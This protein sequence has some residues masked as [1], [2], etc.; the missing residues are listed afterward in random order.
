[1]EEE[2]LEAAGVEMETSPE[3]GEAANVQIDTDEGVGEVGDITEAVDSGLE[4]SSELE[5]VQAVVE[6]AAGEGE[7]LDPIAAEAIRIAVSAIASKIGANPKAVYS[8]YAVENFQSASSRRANTQIALEGVQEFLK[9]LW[10]KIKDAL[11]KLWAKAKAFWAKHVSNVGQVKKALDSM[12]AKVKASSGKFSGK[13]YLDKAP[14]SLVSAFPGKGDLNAKAVEGFIAGIEGLVKRAGVVADVLAGSA[15]KDLAAWKTK[16]DSAVGSEDSFVVVGGDKLTIKYDADQEEGA[17]KLE[18]EREPVEDKEEERGMTVG[19]KATLI[20]LLDQALASIKTTIELQK[21]ADK[22]AQAASTFMNDI[23]KEI[24]AAN[25]SPED[26]KATRTK[27]RLGYKLSAFDAKI[28]SIAA[29]ENVKLCRAV[30]GF[31]AV[32]LKQYK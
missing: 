9:D 15:G 10:K 31:A 32:S 1:M 16:I 4:A 23:E 6:Q 3:E 7:G 11:N 25:Q 19:D 26:A 12:K 24:A 21:K 22:S 28:S 13:P 27:M 14:G 29:A 5:E 20:S 2:N 8:L 17:V 18:L 30:L